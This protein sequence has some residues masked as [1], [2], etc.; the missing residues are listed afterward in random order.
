M[1]YCDITFYSKHPSVLI[2]L[3]KRIFDSYYYGDKSINGY[4]EIMGMDELTDDSIEYD[5]R[6]K[7]YYFSICLDYDSYFEEEPVREY[8]KDLGLDA[9][10]DFVY[11]AMNPMKRECINTDKRKRFY[12]EQYGVDIP[13]IEL[14]F[15]MND[16]YFD[17]K[18]EMIEAIQESL[19]ESG[20][21]RLELS[22]NH[23][24]TIR[25]KIK[26][27]FKEYN[28]EDEE[29]LI[30]RIEPDNREY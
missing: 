19:A 27:I 11:L 26:E 6:H 3:Y 16:A 2:F 4:Y 23:I 10:I 20:L 29:V 17:T 9:V 7:D 12:K 8:L 28:M 22:S 21:P 5:E 30:W 24:G 15:Y 1:D 18:E 14:G 13:G 25:R